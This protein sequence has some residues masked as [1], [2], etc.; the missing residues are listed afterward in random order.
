[1]SLFSLVIASSLTLANAEIQ[2]GQVLV[3]AVNGGATYSKVKGSEWQALKENTI[4]SR[5]AVIRTTA[6]S[7]VDLVLQYNGTVL[8]LMPDSTLGFDK[9]DKEP[10]GEG[11]ITETSL[12]LLA[13]SIVGSQRKLATP[14]TF[15]VNTAQGVVTIV[16]TEYLVRADGAVTVLSGSVSLNYNLPRN[17]GSVKVT[18]PAGFSFDPATGKV[19]PT[20]PDFLKNIIAD[21]NT[22]RQNAKVFKVGGA[23]LVVKAQGVLTPTKGHHQGDN[24]GEEPGDQGNHGGNDGNHGNGNQGNQG[25][26]NDQGRHHTRSTPRN[27]HYTP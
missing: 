17:G 27:P 5:G 7:T 6:N 16:G 9:L 13:G 24:P 22:V 3:Q 21:I 26:D 10:V 11:A 4:L 19:V 2:S 25:E 14:S 20:T 15:K 18:V 1:L 8:R 23:T 12:N